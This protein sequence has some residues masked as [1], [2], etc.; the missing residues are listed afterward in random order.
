[1][2]ETWSAGIDWDQEVPGAIEQNMKKWF[3]ECQIL[4]HI[5]VDRCVRENENHIEINISIHS[6]SDTSEI[7]YGAAVYLLVE[8]QNGDTSSKLVVAQ[9]KMAQYEC[10]V[11]G[12]KSKQKV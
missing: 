4:N 2:Q 5:K 10:F 12:E 9:T 11:V 1:M 3:Q 7:A 8:Y 6:N